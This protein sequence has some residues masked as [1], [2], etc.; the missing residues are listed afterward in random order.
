MDHPC[1]EGVGHD[2]LEDTG[3]VSPRKGALLSL[4]AQIS[5]K[6][7]A[8]LGPRVLSQSLVQQEPCEGS[9]V[10]NQG[11]ILCPRIAQRT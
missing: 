3:R 2:L 7:E 6:D 9:Q 10:Q 1:L 4:I 5:Q 8:G 11:M